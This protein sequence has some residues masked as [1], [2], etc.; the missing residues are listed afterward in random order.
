MSS[1]TPGLYVAPDEIVTITIQDNDVAGAVFLSTGSR[2]LHEGQDIQP[3]YL[4]RNDNDPGTLSVNVRTV[5]GSAISRRDYQAIDTLITF[6]EGIFEQ[7]INIALAPES[8]EAKPL[9]QFSLEL[10]DPSEGAILESPSTFTATVNDKDDP[11]SI[12]RTFSLPRFSSRVS[13]STALSVLSDGRVA[14]AIG[15]T[16]TNSDLKLF[17]PNGTIDQTFDFDR[18]SSASFTAIAQRKDG[19]LLVGGNNLPTSNSDLIA[20]N[21]DG[22]TDDSFLPPSQNPF[23]AG[24]I[25]AMLTLPDDKIL[26][27]GQLSCADRRAFV[28]RINADGSIDETFHSA[29]ITSDGCLTSYSLWTLPDGKILVAGPFS[30]YDGHGGAVVRLFPDG[31][32]DPS[33]ISGITQGRVSSMAVQP[34]GKILIGHYGGH[35]QHKVQRLLPEGA[36]DPDFDAP[37]TR[38]FST[39]VRALTC[40]PDGKIL[41]G[42]RIWQDSPDTTDM[43]LRLNSDGSHDS[44]FDTLNES[45]SNLLTA[46]ATDQDGSIFV[47]GTFTRIDASSEPG[48]AK[49]IQRDVPAPGRIGLIEPRVLANEASGTARISVA[50]SGSGIGTVGAYYRVI[51][52]GSADDLDIDSTHGSLIF[53]PG[54][55]TKTIEIPLVDDLLTEGLENFSVVLFGFTGGAFAGNITSSTITVNDAPLS[56]TGWRNYYYGSTSSPEGAPDYRPIAGNG[57]NLEHYAFETDPLTQGSK[58]EKEPSGEL[59]T[60]EDEATTGE[61]LT[62]TVFRSLL[63]NGVRLDVEAIDEIDER[64]TWTSIWNSEDDPNLESPL[65]VTGVATESGSITVRALDEVDESETGFLRIRLS[66]NP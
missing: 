8:A 51:F 58:A 53:E 41:I 9:R 2:I 31:T 62:I 18:P 37:I 27:A 32:V 25:G 50:R 45:D 5:D 14:T 6:P 34:D 4:R 56:Y 7:E 35:S 13:G 38:N 11:G 30:N 21:Q 60:V 12:D 55:F 29:D 64:G 61:Y 20:L 46:I 40:L 44:S 10:Y 57:T 39:V 19:T 63:R 26:V 59:E 65:I 15:P 47:R 52:D 42:G 3:I 17:H 36:V 43:I 66:E 33:F 24:T 54:E 49:L 28:G 22:S 48:F 16:S 1:L 23:S